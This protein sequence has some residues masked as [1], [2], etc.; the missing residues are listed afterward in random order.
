[1]GLQ[2]GERTGE[3]EERVSDYQLIYFK[4]R[5]LDQEL[6]IPTIEHDGRTAR[7][8]DGSS[9]NGRWSSPLIP[10]RRWTKQRK[11][12]NGKRQRWPKAH[13]STRYDGRS[14]HAKTINGTTRT[15]ISTTRSLSLTAIRNATLIQ[16]N[17]SNAT[18]ATA[19]ACTS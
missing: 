17:A 6:I 9:R 19:I 4:H 11:R 5:Q 10:K 1:V 13:G 8:D 7:H 15:A 2:R 18:V 12:W 14:P 16:P 3:E